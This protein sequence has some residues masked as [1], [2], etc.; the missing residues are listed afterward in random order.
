LSTKKTYT[1]FPN[2]KMDLWTVFK[3][4]DTIIDESDPDNDL[5]QYVHA[6]QTALSLENRYFEEG[7]TGKLKKNVEIKSLLH[8]EWDNLPS[9][10]KKMFEDAKYLHNLYPQIEDWDWLILVGFIHDLGKVLCVKEFGGL[11][12]WSV[13]G[14]TFP[15]GCKYSDKAVFSEMNFYD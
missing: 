1:S 2:M 5:P 10:V 9:D 12:Q 3:Y 6:F 4:L 14:D 7:K 15:V 13:V 11:P 8:G